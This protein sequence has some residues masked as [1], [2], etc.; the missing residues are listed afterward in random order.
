MQQ[1]RS[2]M[3]GEM[4]MSRLIPQVSVPIMISML[5]QAL[6][7]V[8]DSIFVAKFDANALTAV[9]LAFPIQQ[10]MIAL[11]TGLGVGINSLISRKLGERNPEEARQAAKNGLMLEAAGSVLFMIVGLFFSPLL[12]RFFTP[13]ETLRE[14][15]TTYLTIV[16]TVSMGLFLSITLE[17]MLQATGN[18]VCSMA[19]QLSGAVVNIILDPIMIFGWF[20]LPAMGIAGA[21]WATVIGQLFSMLLGFYLNQKKNAELKLNRHGWKPKWRM[22]SGILTVGLPSTVMASIGSVLVVLMNLLLIQFG[23]VAVSVLGVYFKLQ[24]FVFMPVFGLSNGMVPIVGYNYGARSRKRVYGAVKV[25]L[26]YA[27]VIMVVGML[28]FLLVPETLMG[29]FEA[30]GPSELTTH[31]VP[32][33]QIISISFPLAAIGITL[34]TVFQAVGKGGYSLLMSLCRQLVVL[35][36]VAWILAKVGGLVAIWWSFPIAEVVSVTLCL[37]LYR[38]CDRELLRPLDK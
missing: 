22:M 26:I 19:V 27:F 13:D 31:G 7:N 34:G 38:K 35:L 16:C 18:T 5:V 28:L 14:L 11:S 24:S 33:L 15:G 9:S 1:E 12:L 8:V 23:N 20:G 17:R 10:L 36:P 32:A 29:F 4:P 30:D 21:A 3:L 2:R 25:A 6:Y 37:L